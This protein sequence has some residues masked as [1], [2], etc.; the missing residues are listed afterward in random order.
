MRTVNVITTY[1]D[2]SKLSCCVFVVPSRFLVA[3]ECLDT[4]PFTESFIDN[5]GI[6]FDIAVADPSVA[7]VLLEGALYL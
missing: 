5:H 7:G 3:L 2:Q 4:E 1:S 6:M